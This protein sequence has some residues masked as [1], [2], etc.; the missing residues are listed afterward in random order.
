MDLSGLEFGNALLSLLGIPQRTT[1]ECL[2]A[3]AKLQNGVVRPEPLVLDTA[4]ALINVTGEA[5][6]LTE[7]LGAAD[8]DAS[9]ALLDRLFARAHRRPRH[10]QEPER[11][12]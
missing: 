11:G 3:D 10:V 7:A 4:E 9:E 12:P 6:L 2:I 1:I 5:N 8:Q